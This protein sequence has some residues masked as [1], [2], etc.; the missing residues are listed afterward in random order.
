MA[1]LPLEA[2]SDMYQWG[3]VIDYLADAILWDRD[4]EF[5]ESFLD[6]DPEILRER[7]Q[8]LGIDDDYFTQIAPDPP[9]AEVAK[10]VSATREIVRQK[11]R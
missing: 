6:M 1:E 2:S 7:R 5:S 4:F 3:R 10:L 9:P 8:I 11:P